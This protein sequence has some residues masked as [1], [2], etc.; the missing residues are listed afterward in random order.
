MISINVLS[1][2]ILSLSLTLSDMHYLSP[3]LP[4]APSLTLMHEECLFPPPSPNCEKKLLSEWKEKYIYFHSEEW[5]LSEYI[6]GVCLCVW[7]EAAF[8]HQQQ[9]RRYGFLW[10]TD[11]ILVLWRS[12]KKMEG[13]RKY[14]IQ[15]SIVRNS[16]SIRIDWSPS[17]VFGVL[18][19]AGWGKPTSAHL[20]FWKCLRFFSESQCCN[21]FFFF[22]H[23]SQ[24]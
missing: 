20:F 4:S 8:S 13:G 22:R 21:G 7:T 23:V 12:P 19:D 10:L 9:Q 5:I 6:T 14:E 16:C 1:S 3:P 15:K 24:Q 11:Y 17:A 2:V 18:G